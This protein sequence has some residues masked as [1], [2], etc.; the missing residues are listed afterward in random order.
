MGEKCF[1]YKGRYF[2][3][4]DND[5]R[6]NY[7]KLIVEKENRVIFLENKLKFILETVKYVSDEKFE[8]AKKSL[9]NYKESAT[10]LLMGNLIQKYEELNAPAVHPDD[11]SYVFLKLILESMPFPVFI[12]DEHSRYLLINSH[13]AK[14][15]GISESEIIG[16]HDRD[17]VHAADEM[18]VILKS[19]NEVLH[20][21]KSVELP[22]QNFTLPNGRSFVFKTYKIPFVNPLTGKPNILGFSVDITDTVNLDKLKKILI[23]NGPYL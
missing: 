3:K 23:M 2:F 13:E 17:F 20:E 5:M 10:N 1:V 21:N 14:L 16:R 15:F 19:D 18:E 8:E 12:K 6:D 22:N 9:N 4:S 11:K 7:T